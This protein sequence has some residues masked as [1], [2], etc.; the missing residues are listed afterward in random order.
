LISTISAGENQVCALFAGDDAHGIAQGSVACW[1]G[2]GN[3]QVG[4]GT[5]SISVTTAQLVPVGPA[6]GLTAGGVFTCALLQTGRVVCWG[7]NQD[8]EFG[9]GTTTST[10]TPNSPGVAFSPIVSVDAGLT[11]A[12]AT[13]SNGSVQCWGDNSIGAVG[14]G[15]TTNRTTPV[16]VQ[17]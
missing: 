5:T 9:D 4:N 11:H 17:F 15:T 6:V 2:N 8:G 3:G 7:S 14:D 12:C 16:T 10:T 13:L 1:G